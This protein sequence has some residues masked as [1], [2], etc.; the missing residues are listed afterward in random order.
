MTR[1]EQYHIVAEHILTQSSDRIGEI[2]WLLQETYKNDEGFLMD[3]GDILK[4]SKNDD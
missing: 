4:E 3:W 2:V 1:N